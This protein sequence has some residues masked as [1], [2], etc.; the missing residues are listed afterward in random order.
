MT[1][2]AGPSPDP[3]SPDR[4]NPDRANSD[5]ANSDRANP[6]PP[7]DCVE[8]W[9]YDYVRST[10]LA[11]K[12]APSPIPSTW[13]TNP[14]SRHLPSPGR[15]ASLRV[16][17]RQ[18]RNFSAEAIKATETRARLLHVFFH[19]EL[20]A[21][22]LMCW[23]LLKYASAENEFRRGLLGICQDE[24]RHMNLY[25]EHIE[26]LGFAIGAF[27]VRDWFWQRV[28]TCDSQTSFVALLGL[29]LEAAN[30]EHAE[31]FANWF[32]LAGDETAAAIQDRVGKEE[33]AHVAFARRWFERWRGPLAFAAWKSELPPP[34]SPLLMRGKPLNRAARKKA[35]LPDAFLDDLSRWRP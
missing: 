12:L 18:Q 7:P 2:A 35:G 31:R 21:A 34:L 33:V 5:L 16:V 9:A 4:A 10:D 22:E 32:R 3:P 1:D 17:S 30:L 8:R 14:P 28:P 6:V 29:G 20:Q 15:P 19:H 24:I 27:E 26:H 11:Y 13:E 25:R 23:A